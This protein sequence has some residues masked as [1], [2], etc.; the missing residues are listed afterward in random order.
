M[1]PRPPLDVFQRLQPA[2]Q[3]LLLE[4]VLLKNTGPAHDHSSCWKS[5]KRG[6]LMALPAVSIVTFLAFPMV[7]S[8]AFRVWACTH[9]ETE[10]KYDIDN[11]P[12]P[13]AQPDIVSYMI[14]DPGIRC[15]SPDHERAVSLAGL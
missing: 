15:Y 9:F 8:T 5:T 11:S 12:L 4:F 2:E 10:T 13:K 1:T 14:E 7:S 3:D 6:V